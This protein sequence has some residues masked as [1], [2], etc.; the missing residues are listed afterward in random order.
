MIDKNRVI[1]IFKELEVLRNGHFLLTSGRHSDNYMQCAKL[2]QHPQ[3]TEEIIKGMAEEFKDD[4]IEIVIGPA[5]GGITISYEFARQL[6]TLS[7]FTEREN[8]IMT[9]RRGF[10]IP[11]G[12]RVLV[13]EDVITTGGSVREV[14]DIVKKLGGVVVGVAVI[15]DRTGGKI[16]FETKLV[17]AY[18]EPLISYATDECPLCKEGK[19]PL[20]KPGSK[21]FI[22]K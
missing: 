21:K 16:D 8:N 13:V 17:T 22:K 15:V 14:M 3:Y 4:N 19:L 6:N 12:A 18:S 11:K 1:E 5:I 7:F 20:E 9:L 2:L 10:T